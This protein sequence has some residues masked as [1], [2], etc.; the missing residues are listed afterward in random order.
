[1]VH[2]LARKGGKLIDKIL[3]FLQRLVAAD[4]TVIQAAVVLAVVSL[5]SGLGLHLSGSAVGWITALVGLGL[6]WFVHKHFAAKLA[7]PAA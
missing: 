4:T 1:M 6:S 5:V 3:A 2:R 7:K